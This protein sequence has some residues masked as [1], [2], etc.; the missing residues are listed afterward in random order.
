MNE[1][2]RTRNESFLEDRQYGHPHRLLLRLLVALRLLRQH[3]GRRD[4]G[5]A[6][7]YR[8]VAADPAGGG[9]QDHRRSAAAD[10]SV[11]GQLFRARPR[12]QRAP[13]Q[14]AVQAA[15]PVPDRH[16]RAGAR[17][18]LGGGQGPGAGEEAGAGAL[19]RLLR[20]GPRHLQP[21]SDRQRRRQARRG[22]GR[23]HAGAQR[24][25]REG[26]TQ[27]RSGRGHRARRVRFALHRRGRRAVL[28][29]GPP[30]AGG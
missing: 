12:A 17:L 3:E 13:A 30:R 24:P 11:E 4:R 10:D 8:D 29:L 9:V 14:G 18:L 27:D 7:P 21:G 15:H 22:Q 28:G 16:H 19:P 1:K 2:R 20:R 5:E 26:A 25:R 23:A 6:R